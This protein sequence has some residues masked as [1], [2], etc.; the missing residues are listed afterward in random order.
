[1]SLKPLKTLVFV[2]FL[3]FFWFSLVFFGIFGFLEGFF[4]FVK[5]FGKTKKTNKNKP[6]SKGESET[7]KNFVFL[8]FPN[9]C[10]VFFGFLLYFWFSR[11]F[12][13]FFT[14]PTVFGYFVWVFA[15]FYISSV[16]SPARRDIFVTPQVS[17]SYTIAGTT[18]TNTA[19]TMYTATTR[20]AN[21]IQAERLHPG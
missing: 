3:M 14:S 13:V 10:L 18:T 2:V 17:D 6:I 5:T 11:R 7:F 9:V 16:V 12:F 4:G 21:R 19:T 20:Q 1:M 15:W 8:V